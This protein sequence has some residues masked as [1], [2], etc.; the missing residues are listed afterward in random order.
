[1]PWVVCALV[2]GVPG[3]VW[4]LVIDGGLF[5]AGSLW[6]WRKDPEILKAPRGHQSHDKGR[7]VCL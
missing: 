2:L 5:V 3:V 1:M 6:P 7:I 4:Q